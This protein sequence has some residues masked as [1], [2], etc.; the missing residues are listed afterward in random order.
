MTQ[1]TLLNEGNE[2]T[3]PSENNEEKA[4]A[5]PSSTLPLPVASEADTPPPSEE[6]EDGKP[7]KRTRS[8][9]EI[10]VARFLNDL[11]EES[12]D[13]DLPKKMK[14]SLVLLDAPPFADTRSAEKWIM[15]QVE[16]NN[17]AF[18]EGQYTVIRIVKTMNVEIERIRT[19]KV[20]EV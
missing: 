13:V 9:G 6:D 8:L 14:M 12:I 3:T 18:Q 17:S 10:R 2:N 7:N 19:V 1:E 16:D 20:T 11:A 4:S 5:S 15:E